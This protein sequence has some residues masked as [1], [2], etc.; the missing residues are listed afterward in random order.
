MPSSAIISD[1]ESLRS[2]FGQLCS[3]GGAEGLC[4]YSML[5]TFAKVRVLNQ[6]IYFSKGFK[7]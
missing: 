4:T 6:K 1:I 5:C 3:V 2:G 7:I